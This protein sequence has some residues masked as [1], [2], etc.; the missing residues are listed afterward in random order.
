MGYMSL[1]R[2]NLPIFGIPKAK[3]LIDFT[4]T[5]K[6]FSRGISR[7]PLALA[8]IYEEDIKIETE[9]NMPRESKKSPNYTMQFKISPSAIQRN[10]LNNV[11]ER[12]AEEL[13]KMA[14]YR[15]TR[16]RNSLNIDRE[17]QT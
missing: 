8:R 2:Q 9:S 13:D 12:F 5:E 16:G 6:D 3:Q 1:V 10:Q 14:N 11:T 4:T 15:N 17:L 7:M